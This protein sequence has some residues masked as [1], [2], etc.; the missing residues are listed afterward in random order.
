M[1]RPYVF[2]ICGMRPGTAPGAAMIRIPSA[3]RSEEHTSELQSQSN[4]VCRLLLEKKEQDPG[5]DALVLTGDPEQHVL[6]TDVVVLERQRL[7]L[8]EHDH[9][10]GRFGEPLE[11]AASLPPARR[12]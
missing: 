5:S 1:R 8:R 9:L 12:D 2:Y 10:P 11:H 3:T 6:G 4:T 7:F